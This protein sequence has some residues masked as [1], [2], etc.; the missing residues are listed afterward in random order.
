MVCPALAFFLQR[1][2]DTDPT[3]RMLVSLCSE[4]LGYGWAWFPSRSC[5][6]PLAHSLGWGNDLPNCTCKGP[7]KGSHNSGF[8]V[9]KGL[10]TKLA[11]L[12]TTQ[13]LEVQPQI[14][15]SRMVVMLNVPSCATGRSLRGLHCPG[16]RHLVYQH[17]KSMSWD[18]RL[19]AIM[20]C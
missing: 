4:S 3:I 7:L 8:Y 13:L 9:L 18:F 15:K 5:R 17:P 12:S 20:A 19:V 2:C 14:L 10:Q 11:T 1:F 16:Q 6:L